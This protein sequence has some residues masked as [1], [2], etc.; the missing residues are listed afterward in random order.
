M[1]DKSDVRIETLLLATLR[2]LDWRTCAGDGPRL[3]SEILELHCTS[4]LVNSGFLYGAIVL[5][6][7][8]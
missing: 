8:V 2:L 5:R 4:A 3:V 6:G 7:E 1:F